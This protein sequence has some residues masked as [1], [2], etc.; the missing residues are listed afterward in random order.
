MRA[1]AAENPSLPK[2]KELFVKF[3]GCLT[4]QPASRAKGEYSSNSVANTTIKRDY[5]Y[6]E[7]LKVAQ[8]A[9]LLDMFATLEEAAQLTQFATNKF[10][11]EVE[12][13]K[14]AFQQ[15]DQSST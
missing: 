2:L 8:E 3:S 5:L 4:T 12:L 6:L 10:E 1:V 14:K 15:A 13:E 9:V 11:T 7:F